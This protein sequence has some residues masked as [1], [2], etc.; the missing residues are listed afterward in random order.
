[1]TIKLR[2]IVQEVVRL[3]RQES[4]PF[5]IQDLVYI[6]A[7]AVLDLTTLKPVLV[8]RFWLNSKYNKQ[9]YYLPPEIRQVLSVWYKPSNASFLT[10]HNETPSKYFTVIGDPNWNGWDTKG[11]LVWYVKSGSKASPKPYKVKFQTSPFN[12]T[13]GLGSG[14]ELAWRSRTPTDAYPVPRQHRCAPYQPEDDFEL[15][16]G[17]WNGDII[18]DNTFLYVDPEFDMSNTPPYQFDLL[19]GVVEGTIVEE[20]KGWI[21]LEP[22]G[23]TEAF[24]PSNALTDSP[25]LDQRNHRAY[26]VFGN[27]LVIQYPIRKNGYKNIMI[28]A[29]CIFPENINCCVLDSDTGLNSRYLRLLVVMTLRRALEATI[30]QGAID[31]ITQLLKEEQMLLQAIPSEME[32]L[33]QPMYGASILPYGSGKYEPSTKDHEDWDFVRLG[34]WKPTF[35][36][37]D[38]D[39]NTTATLPI[40]LASFPALIVYNDG[41]EF[42]TTAGV[43][44]PHP[45]FRFIRLLIDQRRDFSDIVQILTP[46]ST[47]PYF[48]SPPQPTAQM[49][50]NSVPIYPG[51]S[52][53]SN[54]NPFV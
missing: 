52:Y 46:P 24:F 10:G 37:Q 21:E 12:T 30:G 4:I 41:T 38:F 42:P 3:L 8:K 20:D 33:N 22:I 44:Q 54:F 1:M 36:I 16:M 45:F 48:P 17:G 19:N 13:A 26:G 47:A 14:A 11:E 50:S 40:D 25:I 23:A 18:I 27:T 2:D 15:G 49:G 32:Y 34:Y 5:T 29:V 53:T 35:R 9:R 51:L 31:W 43:Y 6:A 28:E 7:A 39:L